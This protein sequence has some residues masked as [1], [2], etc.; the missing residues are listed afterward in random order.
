MSNA[1]EGSIDKDVVSAGVPS[2]TESVSE[3]AVVSTSE[4]I[5]VVSDTENETENASVENGVESS[6]VSS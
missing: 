2:V 6:L 5:G 3:N 1:E 4:F